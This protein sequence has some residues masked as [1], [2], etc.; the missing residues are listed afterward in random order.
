[1]KDEKSIRVIGSHVFHYVGAEKHKML[2]YKRKI[3]KPIP[4]E[5][6]K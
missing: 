1:M 3:M 5:K 2:V 4:R 6:K